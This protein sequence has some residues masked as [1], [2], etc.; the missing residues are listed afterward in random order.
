[1]LFI[2][3]LPLVIEDGLKETGSVKELLELTNN[4][5]FVAYW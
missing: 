2:P 3:G 1:V 5:R 4:D